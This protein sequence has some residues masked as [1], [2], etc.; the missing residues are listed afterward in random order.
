MDDTSYRLFRW[1]TD[2][3]TNNTKPLQN[4][5]TQAGP[6]ATLLEHMTAVW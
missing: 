6:V 5:V 4:T 1:V 3:T 2:I